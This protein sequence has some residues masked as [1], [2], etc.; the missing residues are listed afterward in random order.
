MDSVRVPTAINSLTTASTGWQIVR[1]KSETWRRS[2]LQLKSTIA[3]VHFKVRGLV[4]IRLAMLFI[5]LCGATWAIAQARGASAPPPPAKPAGTP[6]QAA[7]PTT[8]PTQGAANQPS[9][10]NTMPASIIGPPTPITTQAAGPGSTQT[11]AAPASPQTPPANPST[12]PTTPVV[13]C[14]NSPATQT[15]QNGPSNSP[16]ASTTVPPSGTNQGATGSQSSNQSSS[17]PASTEAGNSPGSTT[18]TTSQP[19]QPTSLSRPC[20]PQPVPTGA[21]APPQM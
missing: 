17:N 19:G 3:L 13:P 4:K 12:N 15:P 5:L 11:P 18:G 10:T 16:T 21:G 9:T 20:Q 1:A 14:V 6:G 8:A 7:T 2:E